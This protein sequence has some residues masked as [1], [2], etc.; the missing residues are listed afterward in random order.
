MCGKLKCK[1]DSSEEMACE[2]DICGEPC[3]LNRPECKDIALQVGITRAQLVE[4]DFKRGVITQE[5]FDKM[6]AELGEGS[7]PAGAPKFE[8]SCI[9]HEACD[10]GNAFC[11]SECP[12][13]SL[14]CVGTRKT[15]GLGARP[16]EVQCTAEQYGPKECDEFDGVAAQVALDCKMEELAGPTWMEDSTDDLCANVFGSKETGGFTACTLMVGGC[17][18]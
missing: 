11:N 18:R 12:L 15:L 4:C 2:K 8:K 16:W 7:G 17:T 6:N 1:M 9:D 3:M 5:E 14:G 10:D 13:G